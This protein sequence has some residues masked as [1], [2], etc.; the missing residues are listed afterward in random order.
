M[1]QHPNQKMTVFFD[2]HPLLDM[3]LQTLILVEAHHFGLDMWL[4][5]FHG[6]SSFGGYGRGHMNL[7]Y[8][9]SCLG[10]GAG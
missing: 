8:L 7:S 4:I 5:G 6:S 1:V 2:E 10:P 9:L 3:A